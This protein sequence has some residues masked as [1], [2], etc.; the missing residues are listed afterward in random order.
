MLRLIGFPRQK[1]GPAQAD[2]RAAKQQARRRSPIAPGGQGL[3]DQAAGAFHRAGLS[4]VGG[5]PEDEVV[6]V[7]SLGGG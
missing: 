7:P 2:K 4:Y 3:A 1:R 6:M 5:G